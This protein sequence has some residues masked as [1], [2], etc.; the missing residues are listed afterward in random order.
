MDGNGREW[1]TQLNWAA[2]EQNELP[3]A[4]RALQAG[5]G[6]WLPAKSMPFGAESP[7][8]QMPVATVLRMTAPSNVKILST[9]AT[10]TSWLYTF[11][12]NFVGTV[13][14]QPLPMAS[15]GAKVTLVYVQTAYFW[16]KHCR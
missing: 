11:S 5:G 15:E 3:L 4:T 13:E 9:N 16:T 2:K 10:Q 12:T 1:L 8:Q 7:A 14:L 6:G